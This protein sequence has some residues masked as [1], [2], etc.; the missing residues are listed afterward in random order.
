LPVFFHSGQHAYYVPES[1]SEAN[2]APENYVK[3][4][5]AFP[6]VKFVMGH[7]AMFEAEKAIEIA[8]K[9]PNVYFD[10]S[11]QPIKM[12]RKA[13]DEVGEERL[14]FGTDWPFG[15]QRVELSIIMELTEG[16]PALREKLL[17]KNAESLVG[18]VG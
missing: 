6:D 15:R 13:I 16:N 3:T 4:F 9:H 1:E 2:G 10:T 18:P 12:V 14:M 5:A 11:F 7:M 17:W 8:K